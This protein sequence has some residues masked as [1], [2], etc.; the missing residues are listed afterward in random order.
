MTDNW[1]AGCGC[2]KKSQKTFYEPALQTPFV[3]K[4]NP[5]LQTQ[6]PDE[7]SLLASATSQSVVL[8]QRSARKSYILIIIF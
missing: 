6:L 7:H 3:A 1:M 5:V 4:K 8:L 2:K